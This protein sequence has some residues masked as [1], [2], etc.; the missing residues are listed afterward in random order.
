[1]KADREYREA[2]PLYRLYRKLG[3]P[4]TAP[5]DLD[6]ELEVALSSAK[7][8]TW[9]RLAPMYA[10][11]W[12]G[13]WNKLVPRIAAVP[14]QAGRDAS[15]RFQLLSSF[16]ASLKLPE[17]ESWSSD[18]HQ[19]ETSN[20]VLAA[21]SVSNAWQKLSDKN[22]TSG[23]RRRKLGENTRPICNEMR[24]MTT[25]YEALLPQSPSE[26]RRKQMESL[27]NRSHSLM[28]RLSQKLA[29]P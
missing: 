8:Q 27:Y 6:K 3:S 7:D 21:V 28:E 22:Q 18:R 23:E 2:D 1:M 24:S 9:F 12:L 19:F 13:T 5:K 4:A 25:A 20:F 29:T 10:N 17:I 26:S 11:G 15:H 16:L 14:P